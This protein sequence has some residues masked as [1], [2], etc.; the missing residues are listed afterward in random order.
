MTFDIN[1]AELRG[2]QQPY[3]GTIGLGLIPGKASF[4]SYTDSIVF[5]VNQS[6]EARTFLFE[7][8]R[9]IRKAVKLCSS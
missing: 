2:K 5:N 6:D 4:I 9:R 7:L 1:V 3:T 8:H